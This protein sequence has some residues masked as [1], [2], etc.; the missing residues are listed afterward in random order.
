MKDE[1]DAACGILTGFAV[2]VGAFGVVCAVVWCA[3]T[4][5]HRGDDQ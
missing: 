1:I 4:A 3:Y 2:M 5:L